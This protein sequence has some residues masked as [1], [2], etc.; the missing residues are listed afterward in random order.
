MDEGHI[1]V[2]SIVAIRRADITASLARESGFTSVKDLL[3]TAS[4]GS[5]RNI[6]LIRFHYLAPGAWDEPRLSPSASVRDEPPAQSAS[7]RRADLLRRI[8]NA[9]PARRGKKK[10]DD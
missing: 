5:G 6:Y 2:D 10:D 1:V 4:H 8:R 9:T 7:R 3:E